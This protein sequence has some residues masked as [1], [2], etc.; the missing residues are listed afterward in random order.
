[1]LRVIRNISFE[2]L[3]FTTCNE[4]LGTSCRETL[5]KE[6]YRV[7]ALKELTPVQAR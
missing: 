7:S 6:Q 5:L 1:M 4:Q 2:L 3:K